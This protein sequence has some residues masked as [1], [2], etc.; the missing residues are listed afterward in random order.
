[1]RPLIRRDSGLN[2]VLLHLQVCLNEARKLVFNKTL[3]EE[4]EGRETI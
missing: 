3:D 1:M 4:F 2:N